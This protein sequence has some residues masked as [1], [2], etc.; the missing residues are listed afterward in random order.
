M[1]LP[2]NKTDFTIFLA[3]VSLISVFIISPIITGFELGFS[4]ITLKN[5]I[6]I[7]PFIWIAVIIFVLLTHSPANKIS[8]K[9]VSKEDSF[10]SQITI[11]ILV[12]VLMMSVFMTI[13]ATWIGMGE[14]N[15]VPI[16]KFFHKW[17]RNFAIAFF[18]ELI[19]AQPIA[20]HVLYLKHLK[21]DKNKF[22]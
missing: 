19:I 3:L 20:R 11:N 5:T 13:T 4:I 17:P 8:Q 7:I 1:K 12:N 22:E 10:N 6:K 15:L 21:E 16:V 18:I 14:I 2:R 9:I